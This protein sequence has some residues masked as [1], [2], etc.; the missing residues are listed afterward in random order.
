MPCKCDYMEPNEREIASKT[1]AEHICYV[2]PKLKIKVERWI[3]TAKNEYYG[4]RDKADELVDM[5]CSTC[6]KMTKDQKDTIMYDGRS[7]K[8]RKLA[9]WW[10][11][12]KKQDK[13]MGR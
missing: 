12:H 5:L 11:L 6:R 4:N 10:D 13:K 2:F 9:D 7:P 8:A 3:T 1:A